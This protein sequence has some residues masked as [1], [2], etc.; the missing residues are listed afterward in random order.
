M[1]LNLI[2]DSKTRS[3]CFK[4]DLFLTSLSHFVNFCVVKMYP[5]DTCSHKPVFCFLE[6]PTKLSLVLV[7]EGE[8]G[9]SSPDLGHHVHFF[10]SVGK[11]KVDSPVSES[12]CV[13]RHIRG[14]FRGQ[15][16]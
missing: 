16:F 12:V 9:S 11:E 3:K 13:T 10:Y 8:E 6:S 15:F 1:T 5:H 7:E 4:G 14:Q 2:F